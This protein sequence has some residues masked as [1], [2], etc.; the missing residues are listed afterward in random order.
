MSWRGTGSAVSAALQ[1][2]MSNP[3][4]YDSRTL[5]TADAHRLE[6]ET[7]ILATQLM[8]EQGAATRL[9]VRVDHD[10]GPA[11]TTPRPK[12]DLFISEQ[13]ALDIRHG[14]CVDS[15]YAEPEAGRAGSQRGRGR[16][17]AAVVASAKDRSG[18]GVA[19]ADRVAL[20]AGW[21]EHRGCPR[22]S[23][24]SAEPWRSGA[25]GSLPIALMGCWTSRGR[26]GRARSPTSRSRP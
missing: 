15:R 1:V 26:G 3:C 18:V 23:A 20:R 7:S 12:C 24:F 6:A 8:G 9:L 11:P 4:E 5:T 16:D 10:V 19:V 17:V 14:A 21:L 25:P 2:T 13:A 22:S